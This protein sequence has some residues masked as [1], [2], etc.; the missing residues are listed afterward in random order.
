MLCTTY[1]LLLEAFNIIITVMA[2]KKLDF[3]LISGFINIQFD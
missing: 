3:S 2:V 1:A